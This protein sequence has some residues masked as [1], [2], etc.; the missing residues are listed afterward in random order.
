MHA[1]DHEDPRPSVDFLL[2][3]T[4]LLAVSLAAVVLAVGA[5]AV[6]QIA[7]ALQR[8]VE[9]AIG[10]AVF[11]DL[12]NV[13]RRQVGELR[14]IGPVVCAIRSQRK[15]QFRQFELCQ[16]AILGSGRCY[17]CPREHTA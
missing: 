3:L 15:A 11:G 13:L 10:E 17:Q 8:V 16:A 7:V 14:R 4:W 5:D 9:V 6:E 2:G 1:I 12:G